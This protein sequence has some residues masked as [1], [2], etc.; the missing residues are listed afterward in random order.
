M[1]EGVGGTAAPAPAITSSVSADK[2]YQTPLEAG[3]EVSEMLAGAAK[4]V[5][6]ISGPSVLYELIRTAV[7]Q[8]G[9]KPIL[10]MPT[11]NE[12]MATG[13]PL[14]AGADMG[15]AE[16]GGAGPAA[17][18]PAA[19]PT[20]AML[21]HPAV[22]PW[23]DAMKA[24]LMKI[25]G[26]NLAK[27]VYKSV[28]GMEGKTAEPT[29]A[30]P[31]SA[32]VETGPPELWGKMI[33]PEVHSA[34]YNLEDAVRKALGGRPLEQNV[35]LRSQGTAEPAP[36]GQELPEG[37]TPSKSGMVKAY[38]YDPDAGE[39]T[40]IDRKTG[41]SYTHAQVSPEEFKKFESSDSHGKAW[42]ELNRDH[43]IVRKNGVPTKPAKRSSEDY[44]Q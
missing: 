4:S 20:T 30:A 25:P 15:E 8:L 32:P 7:P 10:G 31:S 21:E 24:E 34:L 19:R 40:T 39:L 1:S 35:P 38:R 23:I 9:L 14:I 12:V 28:K 26:A 16:E 5:A 27:T 36:K 33:P 44:T 2:G 6:K 22:T 3:E 17:P 37:F 42:N 13:L 11:G 29:P 43:V 41:Q 18:K